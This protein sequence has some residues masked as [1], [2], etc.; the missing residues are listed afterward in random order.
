MTD[1]QQDNLLTEFANNHSVA[2]GGGINVSITSHVTS[3]SPRKDFDGM[4]F[5]DTKY[6]SCIID[7]AVSLLYYLR[8]NGYE[9]RKKKCIQK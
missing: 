1:E 4:K 9:I 2:I 8:R 3:M 5:E 7:G 6:L